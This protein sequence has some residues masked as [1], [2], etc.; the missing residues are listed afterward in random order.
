MIPSGSPS[1]FNRV[2]SFTLCALICCIRLL[3]DWSFRLY[4]HIIYISYFIASY[5]F[6]LWYNWSSWHYFLLLSEHIQ[7]LSQGFPF[8]AI[9]KFSRVRFRSYISV[10]HNPSPGIYPRPWLRDVSDY[11][12][13][14]SMFLLSLFWWYKV[15]MISFQTLFVWAFKIVID[16]VCSCY[17][18]YEM[19]D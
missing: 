3:C 2:S 9:S 17:T 16:T 7:F 18:S 4:H 15:H 19:T 11:A 5:L 14:V 8:L 13:Y 12:F 10:S 6:F 1:P